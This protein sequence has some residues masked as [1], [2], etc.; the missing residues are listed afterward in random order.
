MADLFL[1]V[2]NDLYQR[3][4]VSSRPPARDTIVREYKHILSTGIFHLAEYN[5]QIVAIAGAVVRDK[6]WFLSAFW[7]HPDL[8]R[9]KAGMPL[10]RRVLDAGREAGA[11]IF[12]T[13]SSID[14]TAI[15]AYMKLGM[16]PGFQNFF[17]EGI[18]RNLSAIPANYQVVQ[19]EKSCAMSLDRQIRGTGRQPDHEF[20][21]NGGKMLGRQMIRNGKVT[22][23]YYFGNG[24][25]GPA[26]WKNPKDALILLYLSFRDS[27]EISPEVRIAVPGI[28]HT[29]IK[30]A[31]E[32]NLRL[33][34]VTHYLSTESFG[35]M[36]QYLA[37]GPFLY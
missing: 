32:S 35:K 37:S 15:A 33:T 29:A 3:N 16:L 28:N 36:D 13:W 9:Q 30:F 10:L 2:L 21:L 22:G 34:G 27:S 31:F 19:L 26:A 23:Y 14:T 6:L 5:H 24:F 7:V 8:Q 11:S 18:P 17:F 12:F 20:W 4:N 25:V 1:L